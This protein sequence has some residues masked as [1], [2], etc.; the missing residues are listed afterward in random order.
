MII[1]KDGRLKII[2]HNNCD[3]I[4]LRTQGNYNDNHVIIA[5]LLIYIIASVTDCQIK[6]SIS[7]NEARFSG[8]RRLIFVPNAH[9]DRERNNTTKL[10]SSSSNPLLCRFR[11]V[12]VS[13]FFVRV[14]MTN[15][16]ALFIGFPRLVLCQIQWKRSKMK[17]KIHGPQCMLNSWCL[18]LF[19]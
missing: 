17:K 1:S 6:I 18:D 2:S 16:K 9:A 4:L 13:Y 7:H 12:Y 10:S 15:N 8:F 19:F 11:H 14:Y 3:I 5:K